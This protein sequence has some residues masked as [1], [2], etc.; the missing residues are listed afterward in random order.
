MNLH[1]ELTD[2]K[3]HDVGR[4]TA[5]LVSGAVMVLLTWIIPW[6][7]P[8]AIGAYGVYRLFQKELGEG[9]VS[10]LVAVV[11]YFLSGIVEWLLWLSGAFMV[12]A[13][14]F[15]LIRAMRSNTG[16]E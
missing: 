3:D 8:I 4:G 14:L 1:I 7:A 15:F 5:L 13:G 2:R 10:L 6:V 11:L 9:G 12:G 16:T